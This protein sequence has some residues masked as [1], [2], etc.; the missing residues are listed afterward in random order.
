MTEMTECAKLHAATVYECVIVSHDTG[1]KPAPRIT[2]F[3]GRPIQRVIESIDVAVPKTPGDNLMDKMLRASGV[4]YRITFRPSP[5]A[6]IALITKN[7]DGKTVKVAGYDRFVVFA[8][9]DEVIDNMDT[10]PVEVYRKLANMEPE[11]TEELTAEQIL[12][13]IQAR[14]RETVEQ[15]KK[16][17]MEELS[18]LSEML[19][20]TVSEMQAA[21]SGVSDPKAGMGL[22]T[23]GTMFAA[24]AMAQG[25]Q[26]TE[27]NSS[28]V[29]F[30]PAMA[31]D[32]KGA[33]LVATDGEMKTIALLRIAHVDPPTW[34]EAEGR[35]KK[36]GVVGY[37]SFKTCAIAEDVGP[38]IEWTTATG[39]RVAV[40][41][42]HSINPAGQMAIP[43]P[44]WKSM[45]DDDRPVPEQMD[46]EG[47]MAFNLA[48]TVTVSQSLALADATGKAN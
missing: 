26:R 5:G 18:G 19:S 20:A 28:E 39:M 33:A 30:V 10:M 40:K 11:R 44:V 14:A 27:L 29:G 3:S 21:L 47:A 13:R 38:A 4:Q 22:G 45:V 15:D 48:N 6:T 36:A 35:E 42:A 2:I 9:T 16:H 12:E 25:V 7:D 31:T 32:F 34:I 41:D 8:N 24:E 23:T 17:G 1:I 46:E 37:W 43:L